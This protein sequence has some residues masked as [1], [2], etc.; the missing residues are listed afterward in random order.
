MKLVTSTEISITGRCLTR[1]YRYDGVPLLRLNAIQAAA[2]REIEARV[3]TGQWHFVYHTCP[4][5]SSDRFER[6]AAKD[7]YGL[8]VSV[9]V[10]MECG[11]V[12]TNPCMSEQAYADFYDGL[13]RRLY[14]GTRKPDC[15]F[16]A[17]QRRRGEEILSWLKMHGVRVGP[18]TR[19]AEVGCAAGGGLLPFKAVGAEVVGVDLDKQ[20][21]EYG[22]KVCALDLRV[23]TAADLLP[24]GKFDLVIY[25]HVL[26][27][28]F[29]LS[30][31]IATIRRLVAKDGVLFVQ[32]PGIKNLMNS[33]GRDFL[34][35]LQNAH[36]WYF[37]LR[38]LRNLM[39]KGGLALVHGDERIFALFRISGIAS[40]AVMSVQSDYPEVIHYL[41]TL[42]RRLV[43]R[44]VVKGLKQ[45]VRS[46]CEPFVKRVGLG[47]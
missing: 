44:R 32:V 15:G 18:G 37:S 30:V 45:R 6:L 17:E 9:V 24:F 3:K 40:G 26:E 14:G 28:I 31:E 41:R 43:V 8:S 42:E 39:V 23:G 4:V 29:D 19:V 7:R 22:R 21:V 46:A 16:V 11:L 1:R 20:Y 25:C 27:H 10:C 36:L 12:Q 2:K 33:Y 47:K 5:C 13:Y 38:T 34:R 35:Y